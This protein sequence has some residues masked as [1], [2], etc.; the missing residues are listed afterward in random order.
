[1]MS[2]NAQLPVVARQLEFCVGDVMFTRDP[3]PPYTEI[4]KA[5][6]GTKRA[7]TPTLLDG[8]NVQ[9]GS[10]RNAAHAPP[11]AAR[12]ELALPVAVSVI[13]PPPFTDFV[14]EPVA[15]CPESEQE[16]D[17]SAVDTT[18]APVEFAP[19]LTVTMLAS[20]PKASPTPAFP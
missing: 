20:G 11:H 15:I 5:T 7:V 19:A 10:N 16:I 13:D 12:V 18:P 1:M 14:H 4:V 2:L 8:V 6:A 17:R 3:V 9:M